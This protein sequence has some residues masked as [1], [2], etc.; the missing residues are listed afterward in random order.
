MGHRMYEL[1]G[2]FGKRVVGVSGG[3]IRAGNVEEL[4]DK[5]Q[6]IDRAN[7]TTSQIF[8]ASYV[9]G[10][11][12]L[13]HS[14]RS[15][16]I[17]HAMKTNFADSLNIEISCWVAAE[18]QIARA[19]EKVGLRENSDTVA[20]LVLGDSRPRVKKVLHEICRE[21]GIAREDDVLEL[22]AEK[23]PRLVEIFSISNGE[24]KIAPD[25]KL[26]LERIALLT[27]KK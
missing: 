26:V 27:L 20:I 14:A 8:D 10:S 2:C 22:T 5:I 17:A 9:A 12:H 11:E 23:I 13:V 18:Q 19:F 25:Q 16:L 15:A 21:L 4:L 7:K 6:K 1:K 3:R 24:L